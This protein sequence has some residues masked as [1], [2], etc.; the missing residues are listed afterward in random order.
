M[1]HLLLP[2]YLCLCG[3]RV[4]SHVERSLRR[5]R[6]VGQGS[7]PLLSLT[8]DWRFIKGA[9]MFGRRRQFQTEDDATLEGVVFAGAV[10]NDCRMMSLSY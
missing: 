7:V 5:V 1:R 9:M 10:P 3:C 4:G 2:E 8:E 6:C